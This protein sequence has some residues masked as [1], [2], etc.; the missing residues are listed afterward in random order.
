MNRIDAKRAKH[1]FLLFAFGH[2]IRESARLAKVNR[3]TATRHHQEWLR[4]RPQLQRAYNELW[5]GDGTECDRITAELPEAPVVAMLD[6]WSND[7]EQPEMPR[8]GFYD[9][10]EDA[11][12]ATE[13]AAS[14]NENPQPRQ[15]QGEPQEPPWSDGWLNA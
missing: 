5:D 14:E 12:C 13:A 7:Q 6:A 4:L 1:L 3:G 15:V 2:G 8:S 10:Y 11:P 9:G